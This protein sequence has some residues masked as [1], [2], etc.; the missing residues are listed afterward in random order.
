MIVVTGA[1]GQLGRLV[2]ESLL[3]KIPA[4][5]LAVAVRTPAKAADLAERGVDVRAA[6]YGDPAALAAAVKGA[7]KV[8]LISSSEVGGRVPQHTAVVNAAKEAGVGHLVYTSILRAETSTLGLAPEHKATEE[9]IRG[10]GV[11]FTFLRNGWYTEN[12]LQPIAQ[13]AE[14]G[15]FAGSAGDGRISSATRADYAEAA[16]VVLTG[17]GHRG[18]VYELAG[19]TSW[20][21]P[22]LA[23]ELSRAVGRPVE[24]QD[25]PAERHREILLGAGLPEPYADLLVDSDRGIRGG[26]LADDSGELRALIGRP[27][28]PLTDTVATALRD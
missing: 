24:Y 12:Y 6:D 23:A 18:K 19:D 4:T 15:S 3:E 20:S 16:A 13:A 28:T 8:L 10:S 26:E 21:Y 22:E 2:V 17:D 7:D 1:T 14:S 25:V 5:E 9:L 27:T 11:P